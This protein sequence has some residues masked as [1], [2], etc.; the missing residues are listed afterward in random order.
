ML[1]STPE[2]RRDLPVPEKKA[3]TDKVGD[4]VE[5]SKAALSLSQ[6]LNANSLQKARPSKEPLRS[7]SKILSKEE[8][9]EVSQLKEQDREVHQHEQ[10]HVSSAGG[11]AQGGA[12]YEY[13]IGPDG[14]KYAISGQVNIDTSPIA[15]NPEA[16]IQKAQ[17]IRKAAS[18]PADPSG[19]D[20]SVA[21][22]ASN[23]EREA[24]QEVKESF[25]E[26]SRSPANPYMQKQNVTGRQLNLMA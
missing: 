17:T 5:F 2:L 4:S 22:E 13:Q 21:S 9:K 8:E 15:N 24:R 11:Y 23:M 6:N 19:Q 18:A 1:F 20:R 3:K 14:K 12:S 25:K 10:A 26:A 7:D 16:T